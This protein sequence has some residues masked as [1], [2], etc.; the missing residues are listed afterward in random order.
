MSMRPQDLN[1]GGGEATE[2]LLSPENQVPAPPIL[3]TVEEIEAELADTKKLYADTKLGFGNTKLVQ[4]KSQTQFDSAKAQA[5][6]LINETIPAKLKLRKNWEKTYSAKR[7]QLFGEDTK[8]MTAQEVYDAQQ[9]LKG[10]TNANDPELRAY[11]QAV[12]AV[13]ELKAKFTTSGTPESELTGAEQQLALAAA[14]KQVIPTITPRVKQLRAKNLPTVLGKYGELG[15]LTNFVPVSEVEK[16]VGSAISEA[17]KLAEIEFSTEQVEATDKYGRPTSY[18]RLRDQEQSN[19]LSRFKDR[20]TQIAN[21]TPEQAATLVGVKVTG[22]T[23]AMAAKEGG[24]QNVVAAPVR[25]AAAARTAG[26]TAVTPKTSAVTAAPPGVRGGLLIPNTASPSGGGG[27]GGGSLGGGVVKP[28]KP[29]G[30]SAD[31]WKDIL[32]QTFPSYTNEWLSD[33]ATTHFGPDLI[34]LMV[35]A[36]K[37][38]GKYQGLTTEEGK[39]A[40]ALALRQTVYYTTTETNARDFDQQTTANKESL[41][42]RKKLEIADAYGD[43]GFDD[44]TLT[45]LATDAARKGVTGLGLKQAVYSGTFKQQAAQPALAG[46]ALEGADADRIRQLGKSWNTKV[47]DEQIKSILTGSPMAGSGLVLTEEGLRQQL[48]K[49]WSGAMPHLSSQFDAG[50]TLEDIGSTYREYAAQLLEQTPDQINMF[51]GPYLQAFGSSESGQL[52]LTDWTQRVKSDPKFGWQYTKQANQQATD[53]ALTLARAFG[54][55]G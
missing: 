13:D 2:S 33:N 17:N 19:Q 41:I 7:L 31:A 28:A 18:T 1:F 4:Y 22:P 3:Q 42:K 24:T 30:V 39:Q 29:K 52:S 14:W 49:K 45:S 6:K 34:A 36:S 51:D 8:L 23:S 38:N 50:L 10:A 5:F 20:A 55:V 44:A 11:D 27:V 15:T 53:V 9:L 40:Y 25:P 54:K 48:Q 35:E 32:R 16:N 43:I 37:P 46:R 21:A 26:M 47:S 12:A